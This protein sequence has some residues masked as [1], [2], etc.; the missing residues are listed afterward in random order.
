MALS[1]AL[2]IKSLA[3]ALLHPTLA[4]MLPALLTSLYYANILG[5]L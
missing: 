5:M 1:L 2:R 4:L 3:L